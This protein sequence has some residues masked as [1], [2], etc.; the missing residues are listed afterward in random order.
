MRTYDEV[1]A[2]RV[3]DHELACTLPILRTESCPEFDFR[4]FENGQ[5]CYAAQRPDEE[6]MDLTVH[7]SFQDLREVGLLTAE[8]FAIEK[9]RWEDDRLVM[10]ERRRQELAEKTK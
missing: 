7:V 6:G 10:L 9:R 5:W 8:E 4:E 2:L 3:T 1:M